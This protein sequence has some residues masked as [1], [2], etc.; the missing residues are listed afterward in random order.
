LD[1]IK[2]SRKE[3][4]SITFDGVEVL[5]DAVFYIFYRYFR[6]EMWLNL[7]EVSL[8]GCRYVTDFGIELLAYAT[9]KTNLIDSK[10]CCG[11]KKIN[12]YLYDQVNLNYRHTDIFLSEKFNK[13]LINGTEKVLLNTYKVLI[14]NDTNL[15]MI[16][17]IQNK[18]VK[19][20]KEIIAYS[21]LNIK[22][23]MDDNTPSNNLKFNVIEIDAVSF[24][25]FIF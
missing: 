13:C 19:N 14:S 12:K 20:E 21:Q 16:N 3:I 8:D 7:E 25:Y 2:A 1:K 4:R 5:T 10:M 23:R 6:N 18:T 9:N 17:Y 15:N 22:R 11:C 24:N